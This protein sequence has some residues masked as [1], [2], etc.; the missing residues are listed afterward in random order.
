MVDWTDGR[1]QDMADPTA[2]EARQTCCAG[3][4]GEMSAD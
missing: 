1:L 3:C 4:L 2:A